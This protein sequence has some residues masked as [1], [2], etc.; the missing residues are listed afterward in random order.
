[1][2]GI[3]QPFYIVPLLPYIHNEKDFSDLE[4]KLVLLAFPFSL[5]NN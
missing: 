3:L 2:K 4:I 1:M 5:K